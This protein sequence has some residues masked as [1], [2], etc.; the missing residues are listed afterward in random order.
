MQMKQGNFRQVYG[1]KRLRIEEIC[2]IQVGTWTL[3]YH[4]YQSVFKIEKSTCRGTAYNNVY[5][6]ML[7][8]FMDT[9]ILTL[10]KHL[11]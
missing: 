7:K 4:K 8:F 11:C 1:K 10:A 6:S 9:L 2:F 3:Q 5:I